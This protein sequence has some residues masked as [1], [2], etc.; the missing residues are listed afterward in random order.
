MNSTINTLLALVAWTLTTGVQAQVFGC[1]DLFACE[2][3]PAATVDDGSCATY[4]GNACDDG[5]DLTIGDTVQFDCSCQGLEVST[6]LVPTQ[7]DYPSGDYDRCDMVKA[8][9]VNADDYRFVFVPQSGGSSLT[10]TQGAA[11]TFLLLSEVSGLE[12]GETYDLTIDA[13]YFA[14]GTSLVW[15]EGTVHTEITIS[16]PVTAVSQSDDCSVNGA[17]YLGEYISADHFVCGVD[18]WIWIF[19]IP[20][21][22]PIQHVQNGTS[23]FVQLSA[24]QGLE[25]GQTY[26]VMVRAGYPDGSFTQVGPGICLQIIGEAPAIVG[27]P[28]VDDPAALTRD[29]EVAEAAIYPNPNTGDNLV[30]NLSGLKQAQVPM[31]VY[32]QTGAVAFQHTL[33]AD[34]ERL[35]QLVDLG[36]LAA[37][38]YVVSFDIE[39]KPLQQ[40]LV[41]T[42]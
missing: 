12:A 27:G 42:P 5:N 17:H 18:K 4:F 34:G 14:G 35:Q 7:L 24:V 38:T 26:N 20:G 2:Y 11:N 6:P 21:Q 8:D 30:V 3:D 19:Q 28:V 32:T 13:G 9:W 16:V 22:L 10:Y 33:N 1:T 39:G 40:T 15:V 37:G 36:G 31:P 29:L 25:P 41:V 23:R